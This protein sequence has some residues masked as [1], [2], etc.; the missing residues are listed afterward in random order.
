MN[1]LA[2]FSVTQ[3]PIEES[4][5]LIMRE[6]L[7]LNVDINT[8]VGKNYIFSIEDINDF[9]TKSSNLTIDFVSSYFE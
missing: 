4:G 3:N 1:H 7:Q 6:A 2:N 5:K 8:I 9:F